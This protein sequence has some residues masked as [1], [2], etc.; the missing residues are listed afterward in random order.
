MDLSERI[1]NLRRSTGWSQAEIAARL[2]VTRQ[3]ITN[4]KSGKSGLSAA[5]AERLTELCSAAFPEADQQRAKCR[6]NTN[7]AIDE[8]KSR[9]PDPA[10]IRRM[11]ENTQLLSQVEYCAKETTSAYYFARAIGLEEQFVTL[12]GRIKEAIERPE[13]DIAA[14]EAHRI[15]DKIRRRD[16]P[17]Y[18]EPNQ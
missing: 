3:Q 18:K 1:M 16:Y 8:I 2:G 10:F 17:Q 4:I 14:S 9:S 7:N 15:L 5:K 12:I 11:S 6:A 13:D